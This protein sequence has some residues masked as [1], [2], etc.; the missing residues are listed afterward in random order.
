[1][2]NTPFTGTGPDKLASDT[3]THSAEFAQLPLARLVTGATGV[4]PEFYSKGQQTKANSLPVTLASDQ[5][6]NGGLADAM[7][8]PATFVMVGTFEMLWNGGAYDRVR[9]YI[10]IEGLAQPTFGPAGATTFGML[11]DSAGNH[12]DR[13]PGNSVEGLFV[14]RKASVT[15]GTLVFK[16]ISAA[17]TNVNGLKTVAGKVYSIIAMNLTATVK[18]LKIYN[19]ATSPIVGTDV[20]LMTIP[21]PGNAAGA[22]FAHTFG[23]GVN[24]SVGIFL[25]LTTGVADTDATGVGLNDVVVNIDYF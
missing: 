8:A 21:I 6:V 5:I 4:N 11:W 23:I 24:F 12:W 16:L 9:S 13:I 18:F 1:M 17:G 7:A 10:P 22:G 3:V 19:K 20:P 25:A 2:A 14:A 15:G